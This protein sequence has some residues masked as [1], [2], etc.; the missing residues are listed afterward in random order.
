MARVGYYWYELKDDN[1]IS[2]VVVV[3]AADP[4]TR[5]ETVLPE[6]AEPQ[7]WKRASEGG[8]MAFYP[9]DAYCGSGFWFV[10]DDRL[11]VLKPMPREDLER[12]ALRS[13]T[14]VRFMTAG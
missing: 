11:Q 5:I 9:P 14:S 2:K 8:R 6:E 1:T 10:Y 13:K 12:L 3:N 4:E 7:V